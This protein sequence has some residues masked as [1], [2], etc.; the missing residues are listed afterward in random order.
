MAFCVIIL[1]LASSVC[2]L[3]A[4]TQNHMNKMALNKLSVDLLNLAGKR[5]LMRVD[6]NVPMKD[7]KITNNQRIV[8]ALGTIKYVLDK[9]AKSV[10]LM[11]HL[12][13]NGEQSCHVL[14]GWRSCIAHT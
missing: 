8:A 5:I 2:C 14:F 11:S 10:V 12:G 13:S 7:G 1:L 4:T 9:G 3:N 6:F